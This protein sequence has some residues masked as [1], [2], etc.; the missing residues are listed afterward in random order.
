MSL[1]FLN[2]GFELSQFNVLQE[3]VVKQITSI[4]NTLNEATMS[5]EDRHD[6]D[7]LAQIYKKSV[8]GP[9]NFKLSPEEKEVLKKFGLKRGWLDNVKLNNAKHMADWYYNVV[10]PDGEPIFS[11]YDS[12]DQFIRAGRDYKL[13]SGADAFFKPDMIVSDKI[14]YADRARKRPE[15][16]SRGF[17]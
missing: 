10:T 8:K 1:K 12:N 14:N 11:P 6:S 4:L 17:T 15:R 7:I 9:R 5:D 2:E 16:S 13:R 3:N